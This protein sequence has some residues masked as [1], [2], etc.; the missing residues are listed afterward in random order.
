MGINIQ[1]TFVLSQPFNQN[2][3]FYNF[4]NINFEMHFS[5]EQF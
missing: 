2:T 3:S 1:V 4:K 5:R